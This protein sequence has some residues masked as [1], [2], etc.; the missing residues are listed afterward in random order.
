MTLYVG[1]WKVE[2]PMRE[3]WRKGRDN[4]GPT[5]AETGKLLCRQ[6]EGAEIL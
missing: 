1:S 4:G 6:E 5:T 2:D 3:T